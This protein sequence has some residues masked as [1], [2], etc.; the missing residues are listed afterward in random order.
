MTWT[1]DVRK[2]V[3]KRDGLFQFSGRY[4]GA[5]GYKN[6]PAMECLPHRGP[7]PRG[8]YR[9]G[10]PIAGQNSPARYSVLLKTAL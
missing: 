10:P 9:T 2:N 1:Y 3:F 8:K 7:L 6:N 5:G 4:A